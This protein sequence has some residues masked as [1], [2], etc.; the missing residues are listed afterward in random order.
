MALQVREF[1]V[2][3]S[4]GDKNGNSGE[5]GIPHATVVVLRQNQNTPKCK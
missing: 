1:S 2:N 4:G 5:R 3:T